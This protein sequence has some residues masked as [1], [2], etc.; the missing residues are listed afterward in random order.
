MLTSANGDYCSYH[1]DLSMTCA[2]K[3]IGPIV[4]S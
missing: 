3:H 1:V 2:D 4:S